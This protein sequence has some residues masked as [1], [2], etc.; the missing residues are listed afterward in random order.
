[1]TKRRVRVA[2]YCGIVAAVAVQPV[3]AADPQLPAACQRQIDVRLPGWR[4][5][6]PPE[7]LAAYAKQNNLT[8]NVARADFDDDGTR[9]TAVLVVAQNGQDTSHHIVVCLAEKTGIRAY[10]ID[11]PYC[12]DGIDVTPKGRRVYD[13]ET[14]KDVTYRTAGVSAYCFEKAG[15]TYLFENGGFKRIV[16]S[17]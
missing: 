14:G 3:E 17:D 9:D 16:D 5:S 1:M 6:P 2:L 15:A 10:F 12:R 4:L 11:D 7:D 8:T 13:H